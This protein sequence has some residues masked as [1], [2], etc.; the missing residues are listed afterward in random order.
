[1]RWNL[2]YASH[3]GYRD[4]ERALY[5]ASV[6][7][8]DPVA[9]VDFAATLGFAGVQYARAID[10]T[11]GERA[12]VRTAL[13]RHGLE[14]GCMTYARREIVLA[15]LWADTSAES[16][17]VR[18]RALAETFA[19]A[20]EI[21]ARH[22][23]VFSGENPRIP[24]AIQQAAFVENLKR[25]APLAA[26]NGVVLCLENMSRKSR[27]GTLVSHIGEAY[28]IAKAVDHPAVRIVFDTSHVQVMDGDVLDNL[29][30]VWDAVAVVQIADNPS[31]FEPGS[32]ELN[33]ENILRAVRDLGYAGLVE[34]EHDWSE[35]TRAGEQR[36]LADLQA[37]DG[38]LAKSAT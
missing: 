17:T 6:G 12:Q 4:P 2:R 7:S 30:A 14:T 23:I 5:A 19:V 16:R 3:L 15:P 36:G 32:G 9:Q 26:A 21:N 38:R 29:R 25:A 1:V 35:P 33:F 34:L 27:T 20:H 10:R 13:E 8:D 11:P 37:L 28:A 31:R 22:A 24:R 18:E